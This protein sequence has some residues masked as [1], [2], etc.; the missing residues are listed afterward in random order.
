MRSASWF[1]YL[2]SV[3]QHVQ[4]EP[5]DVVSHKDVGVQVLQ[6]RH[7]AVEKRPFAARRR[8]GEVL[9]QQIDIMS[10]Q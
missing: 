5:G 8:F 3:Q 4:V 7:Q 9:G 10:T 1:P 2:Q 6:V